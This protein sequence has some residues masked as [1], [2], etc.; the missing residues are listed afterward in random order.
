MLHILLGCKRTYIIA[1]SHLNQG[2]LQ[3][4]S[5]I[6]LLIDKV[7]CCSFLYILTG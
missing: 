6:L 3:N 2:Q 7:T 5:Y 1:Y 4:L